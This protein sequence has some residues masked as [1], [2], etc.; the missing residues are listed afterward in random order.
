MSAAGVD[1]AGIR[2]RLAVLVSRQPE[3]A[4]GVG[5]II[6]A[7][8][9]LDL[10]GDV[11]VTAAARPLPR[12]GE[13]NAAQ[14]AALGRTPHNPPRPARLDRATLTAGGAPTTPATIADG[15]ADDLRRFR[16]SGSQRT[17]VASIHA[18][19][20]EA[21][22]LGQDAG[23]N[24]ARIAAV[25]DPDALVAAGGLCAPVGNVYEV[26]AV[27]TEDRPLRDA[28]AGF[29][30]TRGGIQFQAPPTLAAVAGGVGVWTLANDEAAATEGGPTKAIVEVPCGSFA[31]VNVSAITARASFGTLMDRYSPEWVAAFLGT[32]R[33][34]H[35]RLAE[36]TLIAAMNALSVATT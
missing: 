33:V 3:T 8:E 18:C 28:L 30:V 10:V 32:M 13:R 6:A 15:F 22:Q 24:S 17:G 20:D 21:R 36:Q 1:R 2:D 25:T 35:A 4:A 12:A 14:A 11:P 34:A 31:T 9:A 29:Q 5:T 23:T 16:H 7:S 26:E 19:Y 27:G